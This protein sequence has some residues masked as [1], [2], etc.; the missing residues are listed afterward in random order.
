MFLRYRDCRARCLR[1]DKFF[2][3]GDELIF[4]HRFGEKCGGAFFYGAIAM[5]GSGARGYN[6][7]WYASRC[8]ALAQLNHQFVA[9]HARHFEVGD[10]QMAAV[11]G[12]QF[13]G[14][15][16]VGGELHAIA[17][18]FEHAAD[19]LADA[20]GVVGNDDD[21]FVLDAIDG[22]GGNRAAG[23]GFGSWGEDASRAGAGLQGAALVGLRC[24][25]T[26]E[27]D[28]QD[29]AAVRSDGRA[30]EKFYA[31]EIL[32]EILDDDFVFAEDFFDDETD[33]AI[34]GVGDH[35]AEVAV[36]GLPAAEGR[37]SRRGGRL[38]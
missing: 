32:A 2:D 4:L 15:Q 22:V 13:G 25:H 37:D 10:D 34:A 11:L 9:G 27:I 36:D 31:A 12:D 38:R 6:H 30:W 29:Q 16:A 24:D 7:D 8:G 33:L 26:I 5:L 21:A 1:S 23:D 20:D 19:E 18:L 28:E 14:F 17:V 3:R 35:H